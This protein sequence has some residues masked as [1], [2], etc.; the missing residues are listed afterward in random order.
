V[1]T[2]LINNGA[3]VT[4]MVSVN[5]F[6]VRREGCDVLDAATSCRLV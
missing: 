1:A 3:D 5:I 2:A 4:K 6:L